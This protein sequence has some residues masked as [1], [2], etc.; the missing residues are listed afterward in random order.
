LVGL[1]RARPSYLG[2][3]VICGVGYTPLTKAADGTVLSLATEAVRTAIADAGLAPA[4]VDGIA[5]FSLWGDSVPTQ[6]IASALALKD[7]RYSL[8]LE[9]GGQAPC[10]AVAQAAAAVASGVADTV[11]VYRA[12]KGRS[13]K[14]VG[15]TRFGGASGQFRY[16][17]GLHAYPQYIAMWARRYMIETGATSEDLA[18][19]VIAQ[20]KYAAENPRAIRTKE[21]SLDQYLASPM[22]VD[23]F[24]AAD[25]TSEVDAACAVV[26]TSLER[27]RDLQHK[28][29]I[30][31][32]AAWATGP[33]S[34][35]DIADFHSW[36]DYSRNCHS[37]LAERLWAA[38]S[39]ERSDIDLAEIYD[40]FSAVVLMTLEGLGL[41]GRGEAGEMIRSGVTALDGS[42]PVNT[43]G[44]LLREGY[45]HGMNTVA[46]AVLQ[47]QGR[48]GRRQVPDAESCVVTSGALMD[49]SA[50]VLVGDR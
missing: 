38:S 25:C 10:F 30:V 35:Y 46:E 17:V 16:P 36:P 26:V 31:D 45:V 43:H 11:V 6:A 23:P 3:A 40:C 24:R 21:V 1:S 22:V 27:A 18:A 44:G 41:A 12:L 14:R 33:R 28:P 32:S 34:G 4:E 39:V 15:S 13:G 29:V 8:D 47:L 2:K 50:L 37:H 9:L 20:S 49:G 42:L 7:L 5:A 19:V 48:G